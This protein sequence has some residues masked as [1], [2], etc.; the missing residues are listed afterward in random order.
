MIAGSTMSETAQGL[1]LCIGLF[2]V[3][4]S[5]INS[6]FAETLITIVLDQLF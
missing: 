6:F 2:K 5:Y 4:E 3:L 1:F